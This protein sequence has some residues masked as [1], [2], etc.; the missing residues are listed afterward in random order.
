MDTTSEDYRRICEAR[1]W[2]SKGYT[3]RKSVD[4]LIT[5]IADKRGQEAAGRLREEMR[6][7]WQCRHIWQGQPGLA[8]ARS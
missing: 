6:Q 3:D 4:M 1:S 7:Q 2:I 5:R 8:S